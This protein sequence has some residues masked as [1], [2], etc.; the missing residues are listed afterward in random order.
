M[1]ALLMQSRTRVFPVPHD[2]S[3]G[4]KTRNYKEGLEL[5]SC[6]AASHIERGQGAL[7]SCQVRGLLKNQRAGRV[8]VKENIVFPSSRMVTEMRDPD[9]SAPMG[10]EC[11]TGREFLGE[12][13]VHP[14][15]F[16]GHV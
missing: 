15:A 10:P 6:R 2:S 12:P 4:K 3:I 9:P 14:L 5:L 8:C 16:G 1:G 7:N 13:D 11:D